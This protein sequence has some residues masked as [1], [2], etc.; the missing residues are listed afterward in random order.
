MTT[1]GFKNFVLRED[2]NYLGKRVGDILGAIQ[3]LDQNMD[4]MGSR[5]AV[6]DAEK[7]V[8]QVRTVLHTN[9][10]KEE[11]KYLDV[12]QKVGVS[13]MKG[14]EEKSDLKNII[15][16]SAKELEASMNDM[17]MPVN[18]LGAPEDAAKPDQDQT[19]QPPTEAPQPEQQPNTQ[20]PAQ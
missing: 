15:S 8:N 17:G 7:I 12:L 5:E 6:S 2:K 4:G 14:I 16:S 19:I 11:E 13:I 20:N 18:D 10:S 1:S 9:W 3:D